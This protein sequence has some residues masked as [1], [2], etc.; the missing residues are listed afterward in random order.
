MGNCRQSLCDCR[1]QGKMIWGQWTTEEASGTFVLILIFIPVCRHG[2][3][4]WLL[5]LA[6]FRKKKVCLCFSPSHP[7]VSQE[8]DFP[9]ARAD[10]P[11][12]PSP[13]WVDINWLYC[14]LH[15]EQHF[16]LIHFPA[17]PLCLGR[18]MEA[19]MSAPWGSAAPC[20]S[21]YVPQWPF[22]LL[23][24]TS[25]PCFTEIVLHRV[26][27]QGYVFTRACFFVCLSCRITQILLNWFSWWKG[28]A[29]QGPRRISSTSS[30][31]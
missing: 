16:T 19:D 28:G 9:N 6:H 14:S 17:P 8:F 27:Q 18:P 15:F 3:Y 20:V 26:S 24:I 4:L 12:P 7:N 1:L 23:K 30:F 13:P 10:P 5:W 31:L 29:E 21:V 2:I 11:I 25:T 22:S